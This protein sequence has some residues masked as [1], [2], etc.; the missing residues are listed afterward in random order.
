LSFVAA[1]LVRARIW[2]LSSSS[3]LLFYSS[4]FYFNCRASG[5]RTAPESLLI[6]I[7]PII[8][9]EFARYFICLRRFTAVA[10]FFIFFRGLLTE[11]PSLPVYFSTILKAVCGRYFTGLLES[12][13]K[14]VCGRCFTGLQDSRVVLLT[15]FI[16][17]MFLDTLLLT[18]T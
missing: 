2:N 9:E 3:Y 12:W 7:G 16:M 17:V 18:P 15:R 8:I 14:A 4:T 13:V 11:G 1:I 10:D 6:L 5:T